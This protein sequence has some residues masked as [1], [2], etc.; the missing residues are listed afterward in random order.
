MLADWC[1]E[2]V[3]AVDIKKLWQARGVGAYVHST[4]WLARDGASTIT[5][6]SWW[7]F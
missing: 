6:A 7:L 5:Q 2:H 4:V 1:C 3:D